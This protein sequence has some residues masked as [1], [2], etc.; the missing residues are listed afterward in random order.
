[1]LK[2][3]F[4]F[5]RKPALIKGAGRLAEGQARKIVFGDPIAGDGVELI[6]CR[7]DG[8]LHAI[9]VQCPH[10]GGRIVD[11]PLVEGKY[12]VCPLHQYVFDPKNG[13]AVNAACRAAKTYKVR[14]VEGDC[15]VWL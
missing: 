8:A 3:L 11:G 14:E 7:V 13:R 10:E 15:E 6:L 9:D 5:G 4:G 12:A 2:R 1:M